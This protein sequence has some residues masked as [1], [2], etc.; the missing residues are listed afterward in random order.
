MFTKVGIL[1]GKII[2]ASA[3]L[4][5]VTSLARLY[6]NFGVRLAALDPIRLDPS[7]YIYYR[8]RAIS[9][10]ETH[11]PNQN[12]DGF[13]REELK[14]SYASFINCG[15]SVDHNERDIVGIVVD[16]VWNPYSGVLRDGAIVSFDKVG[17]IEQGDIILGDYVENVHALDRKICEERHPGLIQAVLNGDV[18]DTSM[19]VFVEKSTCSGCGNVATNEW[20]YCSH[21]PSCKGKKVSI[22]AEG[23]EK[24]IFEINE[25]LTFFEDSVILPSKMGGTAGGAGADKDAHVLE[26][27]ASTSPVQEYT[28]KRVLV[29]GADFGPSLDSPKVGEKPGSV[30]K[31]EEKHQE[32]RKK[33]VEKFTKNVDNGEEKFNKDINKSLEASTQEG[34]ME[35]T[36]DKKEPY[37]ND[38]KAP[39]KVEPK[40]DQDAED[41]LHR[42]SVDTFAGPQTRELAGKP[43]HITSKEGSMDVDAIR[44][45][46]VARRAIREVLKESKAEFMGLSPRVEPAHQDSAAEAKKDRGT[47]DFTHSSKNNLAS[48]LRDGVNEVPSGPTHI[49]W[50]DVAPEVIAEAAEEAVDYFDQ[51]MKP[52]EEGGEGLTLQEA[53]P[54]VYEKFSSLVRAKDEAAKEKKEEKKE[55]KEDK[56]DDSKSEKKESKPEKKESKPGGAPSGPPQPPKP[57]MPM[58]P[59]PA[60]PGM[61]PGMPGAGVPGMAPK[62]PMPGMPPMGKPGVPGMPAPGPGMVGA[63][64]VPPMGVP[65]PPGAPAMGP[66]MGPGMMPPQMKPMPKPMPKPMTAPIVPGRMAAIKE[67]ARHNF[68]GTGTEEDINYDNITREKPTHE[69]AGVATVDTS[70]TSA[71]ELP[72]K[73]TS[74]PPTFAYQA[75]ERRKAISALVQ[76]MQTSTLARAKSARKLA[77][78]EVTKC[79]IAAEKEDEEYENLLTLPEENFDAVEKVVEQFDP[80]LAQ[81]TVKNASLAERRLQALRQ[82]VE[83]VG[84]RA[85]DMVLPV[86]VNQP[87]TD[88]TIGDIF[89]E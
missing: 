74:G 64:G 5:D 81:G 78:M 52:K 27:I 32:E 15:V 44:R 36:A 21:V 80:R 33:M 87:E 11:G 67:L 61:K 76:D 25:G 45:R 19:G 53:Q 57:G 86:G 31:A 30:Q 40:H 72:S 14:K 1:R 22:G 56:K 71:G 4:E 41:A 12:G 46:L 77:R 6:P 48:N 73:G 13:P 62:P 28:K 58:A 39:P 24:L 8:N 26:A 60:V 17:S 54:A 49:V 2:R 85:Q 18:T 7:R 69:G 42:G 59:K 20:E 84:P 43:R 9:S 63:P 83:E 79:I 89:N 10:L 65:T 3:K 51:V 38:Q 66:G 47:F 34:K 82:Q 55:E 68:M 29:Q 35:V 75:A 70:H 37:F 23:E 88:E 50:S 16:S